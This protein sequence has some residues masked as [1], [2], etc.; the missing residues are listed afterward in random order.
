MFFHFTPRDATYPNGF[1]QMPSYAYANVYITYEKDQKETFE[2]GKQNAQAKRVHYNIL[3]G[4]A[5]K[6][7][8]LN[9]ARIGRVLLLL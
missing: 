9:Y 7:W 2:M 1:F 6:R 4:Q 3:V 8:L 5:A